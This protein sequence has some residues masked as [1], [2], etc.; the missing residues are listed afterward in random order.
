VSEKN[1]YF[2][3]DE[4]GEIPASK[5]GAYM[6]RSLVQAQRYGKDKWRWGSGHNHALHVQWDG[7]QFN[8]IGI[9]EL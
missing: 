7:K 9:V 4:D 3:C 6:Y 5:Q 1:Y 2:L 8:A